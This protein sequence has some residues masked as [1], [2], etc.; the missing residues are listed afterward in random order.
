MTLGVMCDSDSDRV[1]KGVMGVGEL[2]VLLAGRKMMQV[3]E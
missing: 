3:E 1:T 2:V